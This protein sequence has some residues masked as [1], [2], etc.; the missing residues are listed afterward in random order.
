MKIT[1]HPTHRAPSVTQSIAVE[2]GPELKMLGSAVG[3]KFR[4]DYIRIEYR[5]IDGEWQLPFSSAVHVAGPHL[6]KDGTDGA[7]RASE[8]I[9]FSMDDIPDWALAIVDLLRP[10]GDIQLPT[11]NETEVTA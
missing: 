3:R 2:D 5:L 6:K 11:V 9:A 1:S 7:L 8:M 10:T 4:V